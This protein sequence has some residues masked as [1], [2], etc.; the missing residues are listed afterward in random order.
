MDLDLTFSIAGNLAL[1]G[2]ALLIFLPRWRHATRLIAA[3]LI[4]ALLAV[5]YVALFL[6]GVPG[7]EGGFG[8]LDDVAALFENRTVLLAGWIHYLAFDLFIGAWE[9]RDAQRV[10]IT[11][12]LVIPCLVLTFLAGPA[13]LLL[14]LALRAGMRRRLTIHEEAAHAA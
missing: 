4:P 9:V 1:A 11:H 12:W 8:S 6:L 2:W 7:A 5:A 3:V 14:Y 13:G 10:G